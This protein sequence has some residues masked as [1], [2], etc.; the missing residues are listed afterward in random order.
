VSDS[1]G[2]RAEYLYQNVTARDYYGTVPNRDTA[3]L[4]GHVYTQRTWEAPLGGS[5]SY[6]LNTA[7]SITTTYTYDEFGNQLTEAV[8]DEQ[9]R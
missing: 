3:Y 5:P 4:N 9:R 8:L 1:G 6:P 7:N 2:A